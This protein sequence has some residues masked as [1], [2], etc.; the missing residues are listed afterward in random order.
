MLALQ[1]SERQESL[2]GPKK[3][4]IAC[5]QK[6]EKIESSAEKAKSTQRQSTNAEAAL[7]HGNR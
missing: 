7:A 5:W 4:Q 6:R 1:S 3:A 2:N